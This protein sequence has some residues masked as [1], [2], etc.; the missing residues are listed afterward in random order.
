MEGL[1]RQAELVGDFFVA[2]VGDLGHELR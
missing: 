2:L 1:T